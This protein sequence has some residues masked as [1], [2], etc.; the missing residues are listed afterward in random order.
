MYVFYD[1]ISFFN[2]EFVFYYVLNILNIW[3]FTCMCN[4]NILTFS[5][6]GRMKFFYSLSLHAEQY[7]SI[8][9]WLFEPLFVWLWA[10]FFLDSRQVTSKVK[11]ICTKCCCIRSLHCGG[12]RSTQHLIVAIILVLSYSHQL[13][14]NVQCSKLYSIHQNIWSNISSDV[15]KFGTLFNATQQHWKLDFCFHKKEQDEK[16]LY[17]VKRD[18]IVVVLDQVPRK[19]QHLCVRIVYMLSKVVVAL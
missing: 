8:P 9:V 7:Q 19:I 15:H 13:T 11:L 16:L 3:I 2:F 5:A 18:W 6:F 1:G 10:R 4:L 14:C 12:R 17:E